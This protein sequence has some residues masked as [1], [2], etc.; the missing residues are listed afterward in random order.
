[1]AKRFLNSLFLATLLTFSLLSSFPTQAAAL[2]I[3]LNVEEAEGYARR[4]EPVSTGIPLPRAAVK[5]LSGLC[6]RGPGG[7]A[8]PAQF[9][10]LATWPDGSVKWVLVDF[11]A[12]CPAG[13]KAVYT[14][15]DRGSRPEKTPELRVEQNGDAVT[16]ETGVMRCRLD[17]DAFDLFGDIWLDHDRDGTFSQSERVT[18]A[19]PEPG[20]KLIDSHGREISSRLGKVESFKLEA[21]GPVRASVAVKGVLG[22]TDS[23]GF[24]HY[25]ARLHFYA[26]TGLVRVFFTLENYNPTVPLPGSHWVLG[27][28]GNVFFEDFSL[29][30]R[31]LFHGPIQMSVGDGSNEILDRVVLTGT[32]GGI[33]QESSGGEHWFHRNHMNHLGKIPM[34][35]RGAVTFL[36][37][38]EPY[39]VNR[40]DAWLHVADRQFGLAVAVRHF[41]QNFPKALSASPDGTVRAALWP[42]EFPSLHELQGGE[43]KTHELAFFFH[44]GAQGSNRRE[45]RVATTMSSFHKPLCVRAPVQIYLAGGFFDDAVPYD[46]RRFSTYERY[47]QAALTSMPVNLVTDIEEID[48]YG[49]RNFGD[50]WAKN[51]ADKTGGPNSGRQVVSH[52][53]LEYDFGYGMLFQSLRTLEGAPDL[54][55][56]WWNLAEAALRHESDI[57]VYHTVGDPQSS[58]VYN[59]GKYTHTQHGVEAGLA[60]HRGG[61]RLHWFGTLRW[62]WGEGGSPESGHFNTRG[63]MCY[64]YLTGNRR[65]LESATEQTDLVYRKVSQDVFAQIDN[66]SR[67]AGNNIQILTDAYLHTWDEK[68]REAAEK[69]LR[70]T[71]PEKQW[72]MSAEGRSQKAE[73]KVAGFW[74][75][76]ICINAAAR[77]TEVMEEK[78]GKP[79]ELGRNYVTAYADFVSRFLAGGPRAGFYSAWSQAAGGEGNHGP[80]TYRIADVV[81]FGHKYSADPALSKRCLKAAADAFSFMATRAERG[82]SIYTNGKETTMIIGGGHEYTY[83]RQKGKWLK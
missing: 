51:E 53:N 1:M 58:G 22:D 83:Y 46:P 72:Y 39:Q 41:W 7:A 48:E 71:A 57:D 5:E 70:S 81:M 30:T 80:W 73:E 9:E 10:T 18:P 21:S 36:D 6:V 68:Y 27:R 17:Q 62:P 49:W 3:S 12:D 55:R 38:A 69:I 66:T 79:Y 33:Y 56:K 78:T 45:N 16:V 50:T 23:E 8:V 47:Q 43:I 35:F 29:S 26:G 82:R 34:R 40:P 44:T 77:W 2:E 76:A 20:V 52:F 15:S 4:S 31:L 67:E 32:G 11:F 24:L 42:E 60:T 13:G 74:T 59:G 19:A 28:P 61:P 63:Q 64:Y 65:V 37:D 75:A 54:T 25:T 14:L